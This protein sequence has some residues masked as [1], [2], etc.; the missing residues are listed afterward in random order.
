ML[1]PSSV[2]KGQHLLITGCLFNISLQ[3]VSVLNP[4]FYT[5]LYDSN[6]SVT[7]SPPDLMPPSLPGTAPRAPRP[8]RR[9]CRATS[10]RPWGRRPSSTVA[11]TVLRARRLVEA[12]R[13]KRSVLAFRA[14]GLVKALGAWR[15]VT[16]LRAGRLVRALRVGRLGTAL[17]AKRPVTADFIGWEARNFIDFICYRQLILGVENVFGLY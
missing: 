15:L 2:T 11:S 12:P 14:T 3:S 4:S 6:L 10:A 8:L 1:P 5:I 16:A 13:A 7:S 9:P 17:R